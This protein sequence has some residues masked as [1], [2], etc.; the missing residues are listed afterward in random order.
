MPPKNAQKPAKR[1]KL[2]GIERFFKDPPQ[3]AQTTGTLA[4]NFCLVPV[5]VYHPRR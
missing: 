4:G 5:R 2:L 3:S 1:A